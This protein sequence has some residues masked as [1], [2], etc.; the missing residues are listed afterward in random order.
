MGGW[1]S[2][3]KGVKKQT[4]E[5][6][7][8]LSVS[9]LNRIGALVPGWK[10]SS[11][12]WR[13]GDRIR[14]TI[15]YDSTIRLDG[16]GFL[17]LEYTSKGEHIRDWISLVSTIPHY[18]GRRWW[19][20]CPRMQLRTSKLYLP[21]GASHFASRQAHDLTYRSCQESGSF[22]R[23]CRKVARYTARDEAE[24][25]ESL[26]WKRTGERLPT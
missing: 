4:V 5:E 23:L 8:I 21:P 12:R 15:K 18:G 20:Q 22:A 11:L 17:A 9:D 24:V 7:L 26:L 10:Q 13:Q 3:W 6:G 19:F 16:V 25:R 2:G 1:G 14:A